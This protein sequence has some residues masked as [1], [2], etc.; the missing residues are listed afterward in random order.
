ME[1]CALRAP[2]PASESLRAQHSKVAQTGRFG[3]RFRH[4]AAFH[5]P[6][7]GGA[8]EAELQG[9]NVDLILHAGDLAYAD[10]NG[11]RWDSYG[12]LGEKLFAAVPTGEYPCLC[13][14]SG[15]R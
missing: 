9:G 13:V 4:R 7:A 3:R 14:D 2:R 15:L 12:R 8:L 5:P 10:G 11:L 6:P 1:C